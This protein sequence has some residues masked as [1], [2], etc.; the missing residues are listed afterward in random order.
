[1]RQIFNAMNGA[2]TCSRRTAHSQQLRGVSSQP[3]VGLEAAKGAARPAWGSLP[4]CRFASRRTVKSEWFHVRHLRSK[5]RAGP[6]SQARKRR[7]WQSFAYP[8][9]LAAGGISV[10][11]G[12]ADARRP[13][14][15]T[16]R[17][18]PGNTR[19]D[20]RAAGSRQH[21]GVSSQ[22]YVGPESVKDARV[23][24]GKTRCRRGFGDA[25]SNPTPGQSRRKTLAS[26]AVKRDAVA[27]SGTRLPVLRCAETLSPYAGGRN[28]F[29]AREEDFKH[30]P[31]LQRDERRSAP[32]VGFPTGLPLRRCV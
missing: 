20:F 9:R 22:P 28:R 14:G 1:M 13:G 4:A 32:G 26:K 19:R 17:F 6:P 10:C 18:P 21:R 30:T 27:A 7:A 31:G 15:K 8:G 16:A 12:L 29:P 23:Q 2:R 25:A 5:G 24:G 3:Y 11:F